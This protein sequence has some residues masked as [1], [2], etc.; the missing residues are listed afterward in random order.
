MNM[1]TGMGRTEIL[2]LLEATELEL[3]EARANERAEIVRW[4]RSLI[5]SGFHQSPARK[6]RPSGRGGSAD[7][8]LRFH[9]A[10]DDF[11]RSTSTRYGTVT[12]APEVS[13]P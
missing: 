5:G 6:P 11:E 13:T 1:R 12:W 4:L 8:A 3:K 10:F 2:A 7:S 9:V